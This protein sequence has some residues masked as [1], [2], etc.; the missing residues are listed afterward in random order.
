MLLNYTVYP[1]PEF[2][3]YAKVVKLTREKDTI[4][5]RLK[6]QKNKPL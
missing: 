1:Y 2:G 6:E 3:K 5:V 4:S